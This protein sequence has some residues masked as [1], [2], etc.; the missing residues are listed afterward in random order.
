MR[1]NQLKEA[2]QTI[3][4]FKEMDIESIQEQAKQWQE[5]AENAEKEF[6]NKL[7]ELEYKN[8][9]E[10]KFKDIKFTSNSAKESIYK[11]ALEAGFKL[12]DGNMLGFDDFIKMQK[13]SDPQAFDESTEPAAEFTTKMQSTTST[14]TYDNAFRASLGLPV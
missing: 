6:S 13:D 3:T 8:A 1:E 10:S 14:P 12:H 5:K 9:L 2:T 11:K 7:H 4:G